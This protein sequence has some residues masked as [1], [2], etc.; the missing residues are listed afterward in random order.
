[1][2]PGVE[3]ISAL[4]ARAREEPNLADAVG[5]PAARELV[6]TLSPALR[7]LEHRYYVLA[8]PLVADA[9]YD[10]LFRLLKAIEGRFPQL[11]TADSPTRR[12]HQGLVKDFPKVAH[13]A[14]MLSLDNAFDQTDLRLFFV[15]VLEGAGL[16]RAGKASEAVRRRIEAAGG[17]AEQA[18]LF[19]SPAGDPFAGVDGADLALSVEPK[20]DGAGITLLYGPDGL[21][22]RGATRGDGAVGDDITTNVRTIRSIP[23]RI[24]CAGHGIAEIE[25]RGEALM[26]LDDFAALNRSRLAAGEAPFANPRNST[27]GSLRMQDPRVVADRRISAW[28]YHVSHVALAD[29]G[30]PMARWPCHSDRLRLLE[31]LGFPVAPDWAVARGVDAA[32]DLVERWRARRDELPFEIDGCVVK[33]DRLKLQEQLGTTAHHPRWATA[34]KLDARQATTLL[35]AVDVNVGRTGAVTPLAVLRPVELGGVTVSRASLFNFPLLASLDVRPGDTVLVE[36]AGDVIPHVV[37]A[38]PEFRPADAVPVQPPTR[39][40][41]CDDPLVWDEPA[42][43]SDDEAA[44]GKVLRCVNAACPAQRVEHVRHFASRGAMDIDGL[45]EA[46]AEQLV[47]ADLVRDVADL[48]RL[49]VDDLVAL[50]RMGQKSSENLVAAIDRSRDRPLRRLLAGLGIRH[51]GAKV[52][53]V[54]AARFGSLAALAAASVDDLCAIDGVGAVMADAVVAWFAGE[55][56]RDLLER[57]ETAGVRVADPA[58]EAPDG[59]AGSDALAGEV[60]VFTGALE[61]LTR[62]A[63][64]ELVMAHGAKASG[65]VSK[66]TTRLVAGPGAGSKLAKARSL[67]VEV[68]D[69]DAFFALLAERGC[70]S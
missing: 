39:C 62:E 60:F 12:I 69:E 51:V 22:A 56:N 59:A 28:F 57:L 3:G 65:S 50:E 5:E 13:R 37:K 40:P 36:R 14:P 47:G 9:D 68:L 18:E 26:K 25:V 1:M 11:A 31:A 21:L 32:W 63:A 6:A 41:S 44:T 19:G 34:V 46:L 7:V 29:G 35:E 16:L 42:G 45:G 24:D 70:T 4:L 15:G 52:A 30:D 58:T 23:L 67:D 53:Q 61:R 33:V 2:R 66:R 48:Y 38:I 27:A 8:E 17:D 10:R 49:R 54:L 64:A 20:L 55:H 43:D